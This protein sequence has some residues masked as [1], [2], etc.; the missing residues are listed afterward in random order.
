MTEEEIRL[1]KM[2]AEVDGNFSKL[3]EE[4]ELLKNSKRYSR[5]EVK[6]IA[7]SSFFEGMTWGTDPDNH[8]DDY[9]A[10][11]KWF[12][13]NY[14][15]M[16]NVES[17]WVEYCDSGIIHLLFNTKER[18]MYFH[19]YSDHSY[20]IGGMIGDNED[21]NTWKELMCE[22]PNDKLVFAEEK[23]Y[24]STVIQNKDQISFY[25]IPFDLIKSSRTL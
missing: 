4:N 13:K 11:E 5:E 8:Q 3:Y 16:K 10:F 14:P 2:L 15:F 23:I 7:Q 25:F 19:Q 1:T 24:I 22:I 17:Y 21:Y 12:D 6:I 9:E 18:W 20:K